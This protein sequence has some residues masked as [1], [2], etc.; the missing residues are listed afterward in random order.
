MV[1][2]WFILNHLVTSSFILDDSVD[3][4]HNRGYGKGIVIL[5]HLITLSF[6]LYVDTLLILI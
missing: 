5:N 1:R 2:G 3:T 4:L 6:K